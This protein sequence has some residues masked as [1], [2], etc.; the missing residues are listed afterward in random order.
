MELALEQSTVAARRL[1]RMLMVVW[2][3]VL[4]TGCKRATDKPRSVN[5]SYVELYS[6]GS[7]L[8]AEHT[9]VVT[10]SDGNTWYRAPEPALNLSH[11]KLGETYTAPWVG[12][13]YS[14]F[15]RVKES[16]KPSLAQWTRERVGRSVGV[17]VDG[18]LTSVAKLMAE[19]RDQIS[20]DGFGT[21]AEAQRVASAIKQGGHADPG[22]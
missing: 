4:A 13:R 12:G 8:D 22:P 2:V 20:I 16:Q 10:D 15:L 1:L 14:V 9:V 5:P 18:R 7:S 3:C 6:L 11:F 21:Q 17:L 19:V